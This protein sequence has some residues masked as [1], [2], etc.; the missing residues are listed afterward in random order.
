MIALLLLAFLG[1]SLPLQPVRT[2]VLLD[3]SPSAR[4]GVA[5]VAS[6]LPQLPNVRYLAFAERAREVASAS[7]R[8]E[9]LGEGTDINTALLEAQRLEPDRIVLLSDGLSQGEVLPVPTPV[10]AFWT[11]PSPRISLSLLPPT[12]PVHGETVEVR[13]LLEST[14]DTT[15]RLV[16]EGPAGRQERQ[17]QVKAGRQSFGYRFA[18]ERPATV[19]ARVESELGQ[20]G[21]Q[22]QVSPADKVRVWVLGDEA[23]A[24]Y[25]EA[26]GFSVE[27]RHRVELPI[28]ADVV[29]LGVSTR[30]LS[31]AEIDALQDFLN[32]GGSLLWTATPRGLFFG[33]WER[34]SLSEAIPLEPLEHDGGVGLVLVLD[35]SGSMLQDDKLG[36]AVTGALELIRSAREQDYVGVVAFSSNYRWVFRPRRMTPQGRKAAES[37]LLAARAG[38]GTLIGGAYAE[39][40]RALEPLPVEDKR[41]LVMTDGQV[42]DPIQPVLSAAAQGQQRK[43]FTSSVALGA[44]AD[45]GFLRELAQQG[46]GSFWYVPSPSDLPRF[47]LEEAQRQFKRE[48]LE[49]SF[50]LATRPWASGLLYAQEGAVLAVGESGRGRVAALATD[51]SRSWKDWKGASGFLGSLLRWLS[52]T[53]ARPRV[54]AV[55]GEDGVRVL[56]E[57]QFERP[58]LRYAGKAQ[59]F[60]PVGPLRYEARLPYGARGEAAVLEAGVPRLNLTLPAL[61]EWRL[62]DGRANLRA[63][64]E[65]SGGRLLGDLAELTALPQRKALELRPL[66]V[67]LALALFVLERYLE[68]RRMGAVGSS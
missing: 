2:V 65:A 48:A 34:S 25:L 52:Q 55:R 46:G 30:D 27:R 35:V 54:Q 9:D 63:L 16:I 33:G 60:L 14:A 26:Q 43:I 1:P 23:L 47:F 19:R 56:L 28:Q 58:A 31:E 40:V 32:Q 38:G 8:R 67:A 21:A 20:D 44:D 64:A 11:A 17:V 13:V 7:A 59:D 37:L 4:E 10:Y 49:G 45:Q 66:L 29:A 18:L 39:A 24:R 3:Q 53:P 22:V 12:Y 51:L 50:A 42:A 5:Q 6:T 68:W 41:I 15:A 61:P 62:E 57:G 36:L